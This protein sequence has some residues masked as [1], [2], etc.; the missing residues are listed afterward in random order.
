LR[1]AFSEELEEKP[2][3]GKEPAI[4]TLQDAERVLWNSPWAK[5]TSYR[6]FGSKG[7]I[8]KFTFYVRLQ[9]AQPVRLAL[10]R[11]FQMQQADQYVIRADLSEEPI[12][13]LAERIRIPDEMVFSLIAFPPFIHDRLNGLSVEELQKKT[14]LQVG[15]SGKIRLKAFVPPEKTTFGEA[16]FRFPRPEIDPVAQKIRFVTSL[17]VPRQIAIKAD[18]DVSKLEFGRRLAY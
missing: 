9:S 6:F 1:V 12:E 8:W 5:A 10:A 3:V 4:W 7:D 16:W 17:E 2:W 18:F 13:E 15:R 14:Y 11:A